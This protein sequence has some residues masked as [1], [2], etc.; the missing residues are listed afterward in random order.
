M[1][2]SSR[3]TLAQSG[4]VPEQ[5]VG[6]HSWFSRTVIDR[7]LVRPEYSPSTLGNRPTRHTNLKN[8]SDDRTSR[9]VSHGEQDQ[10]ILRQSGPMV[11]PIVQMEFVIKPL[12]F[13]L[14]DRQH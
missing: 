10:D 9:V 5:M 3:H 6:K 2:K 8:T 12:G 13:Q 14:I 1:S 7:R 11:A 4:K